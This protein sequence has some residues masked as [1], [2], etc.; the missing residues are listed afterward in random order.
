MTNGGLCYGERANKRTRCRKRRL[1][2][3]GSTI[4]H[5]EPKVARRER[6]GC[7]KRSTPSPDLDAS[8]VASKKHRFRPT[9]LP[10]RV[11][12]LR[13]LIW[14]DFLGSHL[15]HGCVRTS[16]PSIIFPGSSCP[17]MSVSKPRSNSELWPAKC[18]AVQGKPSIGWSEVSSVLERVNGVGI[19]LSP[20]ARPPK[21]KTAPRRDRTHIPRPWCERV[22]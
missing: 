11:L 13:L 21:P 16:L 4:T 2:S 9:V 3:T 8:R 7:A 6:R 20:R 19:E 14:R 1:K 10:P 5:A 18:I 17:S 12:C 22:T 15:P